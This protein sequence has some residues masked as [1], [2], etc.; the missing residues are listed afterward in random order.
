MKKRNCCHF[1]LFVLFF[2]TLA[3]GA[4][5]N[6]WRGSNRDGIATGFTPP[7]TYPAQLK[8]AWSVEVGIGHSSP[9]ISGNSIFVFSRVDEKEVVSA[10]EVASGKPLWKD[11]YDAPYTMN[12]AAMSH[13]KGPKSTP[14]SFEWEAIHVWNFWNFILLRRV[15]REAFVEE[16]FQK[17]IFGYCSGFWNR[18]VSRCRQRVV[19]CSCGRT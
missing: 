12:M 13:G 4:D 2:A 18:H 9:V 5:W 19:D 8:K 1:I 14:D 16:R 10:Y 3:S 11:T 6:Q 17:A 7:K 15:V